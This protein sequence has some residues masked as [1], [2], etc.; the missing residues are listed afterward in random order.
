MNVTEQVSPL[1]SPTLSGPS[2]QKGTLQETRAGNAS[3]S[4]ECGFSFTHSE[5]Q[6]CFSIRIALTCR[7]QK[8][9]LN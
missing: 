8:S 5:S 4:A 2:E 9:S 1:P 3:I 6:S 7:K